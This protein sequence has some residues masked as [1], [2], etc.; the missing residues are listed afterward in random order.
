[1]ILRL[2][3]LHRKVTKNG[4]FSSKKTKKSI[5]TLIYWQKSITFAG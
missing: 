5:K 1:M 4:L 2:S 3:P